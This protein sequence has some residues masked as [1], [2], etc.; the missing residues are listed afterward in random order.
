M[1]ATDGLDH[2]L[3]SDTL[4]GP[5][6]QEAARS[7]A[8]W[9]ARLD[10]L[11]VRRV[12]ARRE[13]RAM[14]AAW[15]DRVRRAEFDRLGG[16]P[17]GRLAGVAAILRGQR[18]GAIVRR[19]CLVIVPRRLLRGIVTTVLLSAVVLGVLLGMVIARLF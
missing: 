8:Y 13:A 17:I 1:H 15:E 19:A 9:R 4:R 16:G 14:V 3:L 7:L 5:S 6:T 12:A 18:P 11:P 2:D 10:R